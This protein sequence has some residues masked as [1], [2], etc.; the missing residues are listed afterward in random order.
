VQAVQSATRDLEALAGRVHEQ[1][2]Q[3]T[4]LLTAGALSLVA[5][6]GLWYVAAGLLPRSAGDWIAASLIGGN[7]WQAPRS[8]NY[9][10]N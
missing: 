2:E 5:G 4:W 10:S 7:R 6:V 3:R 8:M 9:T 1:R